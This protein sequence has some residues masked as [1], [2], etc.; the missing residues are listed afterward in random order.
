MSI[1]APLEGLNIREEARD[2]GK[3]LR[4]AA[5]FRASGDS[6]TADRLQRAAFA[7][8]TEIFELLA[9]PVDSPAAA[10]PDALAA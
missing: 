10:R 9:R 2:I 8:A 6:V 5:Q 3:A 4:I 7:R 1:I